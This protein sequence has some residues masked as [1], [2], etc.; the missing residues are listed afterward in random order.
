MMISHVEDSVELRV[1]AVVESL[2]FAALYVYS[3]AGVTQAS[4]RSRLLRALVKR[5]YAPLIERAAMRVA[6]SFAGP[7]FFGG[8]CVLV[9]VPGC[10]PVLDV[11]RGVAGRIAHELVRRRLGTMIWPGIR[12]AR[13]VHKSGTARPGDRP[14]ILDHCTTFEVDEAGCPGESVVLVDD[15]VTK[16]RTLLAAAMCL[17]SAYPGVSIRAFALLRTMGRVAE[18]RRLR[19]PCR[20][21]IRWRAGD[22]CRQP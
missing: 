17:K 11:E 10:Q 8:S 7:P 15:V 1:P 3:P 18:V 14:T 21:L 19:D 2:E 5:G 16:G 22:A 20:G 9:P 4:R 13:E 12:R 6:A